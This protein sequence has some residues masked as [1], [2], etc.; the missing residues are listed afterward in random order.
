M[1]LM[2]LRVLLWRA[3]SW[4]GEES[5]TRRGVQEHLDSTTRELEKERE[6]SASQRRVRFMQPRMV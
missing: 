4:Q 5:S 1:L 6:A 2:V 3:G